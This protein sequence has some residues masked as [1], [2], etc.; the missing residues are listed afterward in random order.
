MDNCTEIQKNRIKRSDFSDVQTKKETVNVSPNDE[1]SFSDSTSESNTKSLDSN[2]AMSSTDSNTST[3]NIITA[4][5]GYTLIKRCTPPPKTPTV[6]SQK[7]DSGFKVPAI[8]L[9]RKAA[10]ASST[11]HKIDDDGFKAPE[12]IRKSDDSNLKVPK[13]PARK[14]YENK[15][16]KQVRFS[17]DVHVRFFGRFEKIVEGEEEEEEEEEDDDFSLYEDDFSVLAP[18]NSTED[19]P[20]IDLDALPKADNYGRNCGGRLFF[21]SPLPEDLIPPPAN[22]NFGSQIHHELNASTINVSNSDQESSSVAQDNKINPINDTRMQDI[23]NIPFAADIPTKA[24]NTLRITPTAGGKKYVPTN[25]KPKAN[26]S[27]SKQLTTSSGKEVNNTNEEPSTSLYQTLMG[28]ELKLQSEQPTGLS[29][30]KRFRDEE[31]DI[32]EALNVKL[33]TRKKNEPKSKPVTNYMIRSRA[34]GVGAANVMDSS[35]VAPVTGVATVIGDGAF[36]GG[37]DVCNVVDGSGVATVSDVA[38]VTGVATVI[39]DGACLNEFDV[40]NV[41]DG[42]GVATV[43]EIATICGVATVSGAAPVTGVAPDTDV[44]PVTGDGACL[45]ESD[46]CNVVMALV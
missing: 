15:P 19:K 37:S 13:A 45:G 6:T 25:P 23:S 14:V 5:K 10:Q 43:S 9:H 40:C 22:S 18:P 26:S 36:L 30:L 44:A 12:P 38:P 24:V 16:K 17:R 32:V 11:A 34:R 33:A 41:V 35:S 7:N 39:G 21:Y 31:D 1:Q 3:H 28:L 8:P 29:S 42:S 4:R 20:P 2:L 46:V 27:N